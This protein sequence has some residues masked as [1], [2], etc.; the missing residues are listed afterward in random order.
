[1][2]I[3]NL[4]HPCLHVGSTTLLFDSATWYH[5]RV[6]DMVDQVS[7]LWPVAVAVSISHPLSL[8]LHLS[9]LLFLSCTSAQLLLFLLDDTGD[10]SQGGDCQDLSTVHFIETAPSLLREIPWITFKEHKVLYVYL[11]MHASFYNVE[12]VYEQQVMLT[13]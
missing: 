7:G 12:A 2:A 4:P 3:L 8:L 1:M 13:I 11:S 6:L 5:N 9:H 10:K